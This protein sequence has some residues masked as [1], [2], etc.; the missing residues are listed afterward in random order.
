MC[1][2]GIKRSLDQVIFLWFVGTEHCLHASTGRDN[3]TRICGSRKIYYVG[4]ARGRCRPSQARPRLSLISRRRPSSCPPDLQTLRGEVA[5]T[6]ARRAAG[7]V[8]K[9]AD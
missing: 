3:S 2:W 4:R 1:A 8:G 7:I 9:A 6:A 5:G